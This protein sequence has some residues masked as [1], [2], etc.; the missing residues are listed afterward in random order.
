MGNKIRGVTFDLAYTLIY[1]EKSFPSYREISEMLTAEGFEIYPQELEAA[2]QYVF[3]IDFTKGNINSWESW[4]NK[5]FSHL[6]YPNPPTII[7]DKYI[8]LVKPYSDSFRL[9]DD[10]L[11]IIEYLHELN[12]K[13]SVVTTIPE[14]RFY[15]TFRPISKYFDCIVT[16]RNAKCAKGNP[17]MYNFDLRS[18][19][20]RAEENLFV[21]DDLYYDIEIPK[22]MGQFTGYL[23]RNATE[24]KNSYFDY[25]F[26]SLLDIKNL[27]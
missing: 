9:Y 16:G 13:L 20:V 17:K 18:K 6:G 23:N 27:L 8:K 25:E 10:V 4:S 1:P 22:K 26:S 21:G 14:F 11:P 15:E 24:I 7:L 5:I 12:I 19:N 2:R 3:F